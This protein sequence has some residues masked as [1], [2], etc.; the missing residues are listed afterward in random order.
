MYLALMRAPDMD[1]ITLPL[2]AESTI[3]ATIFRDFR[4]KC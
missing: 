3:K 1:N 2:G 4:R